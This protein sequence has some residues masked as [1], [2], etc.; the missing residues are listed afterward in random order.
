MSDDRGRAMDSRPDAL[1]GG[2][3]LITRALSAM[4]YR[5]I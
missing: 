3:L 5:H 2:L 4:L 1:R